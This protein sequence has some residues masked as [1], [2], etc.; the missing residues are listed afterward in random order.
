V[1]ELAH[2]DPRRSASDEHA[3]ERVEVVAEVARVADGDRSAWPSTV[4]VR[5]ADG[6]RDEQLGVGDGGRSERGRSRSKST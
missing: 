3:R 2:R 5:A 4:V 6:R 1:G